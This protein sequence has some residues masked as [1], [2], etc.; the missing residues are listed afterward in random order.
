[1]PNKIETRIDVQRNEPSRLW[2]YAFRN[3][4]VPETERILE[5]WGFEM[6]CY[7]RCTFNKIIDG[8]NVQFIPYGRFDNISP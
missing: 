7:D 2:T 8:A 1:M 6:S 4:M 3:I 5:G